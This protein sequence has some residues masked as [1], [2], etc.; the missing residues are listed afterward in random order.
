[1]SAPD[2]GSGVGRHPAPKRLAMLGAALGSGVGAGLLGTS[3][4]GHAYFS[5]GSVIPWGAALALLLLACVGIFVGLWARSAWA[6]VWCG[7]AAYATAGVLSLRLG[8]FGLITGNLQG[9]LWL[10]G[11]A[12]VTPLAAL[13]VW[14]LLRVR[15]KRQ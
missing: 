13:L 10:Y 15:N 8:S 12:V 2:A 5:G 9:T 1:M 14:R 11:I 6:V 7:A 4:H 3:L